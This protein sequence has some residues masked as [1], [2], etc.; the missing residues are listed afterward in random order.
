M[1]SL[2]LLVSYDFH[3]SLPFVFL[4]SQAPTE[5]S[6]SIYLTQKSQYIHVGC[7]NLLQILL[8]SFD[9]SLKFKMVTGIDNYFS[10]L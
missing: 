5:A 8:N 1:A 6:S 9:F 2:T 7:E 3:P 4:Y 10:N